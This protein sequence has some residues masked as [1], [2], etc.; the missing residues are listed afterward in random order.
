MPV[1]IVDQNGRAWLVNQAGGMVSNQSCS[2][3]GVRHEVA[4]HSSV[5]LVA[6]F[7]QRNLPTGHLTGVASAIAVLS[8]ALWGHYSAEDIRPLFLQRELTTPG[9]QHKL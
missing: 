5:Q 2:D 4:M 3:D 8:P 9:P 6:E 7:M 1:Q